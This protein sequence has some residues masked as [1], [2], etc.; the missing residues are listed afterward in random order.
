MSPFYFGS[1]IFYL[2]WFQCGVFSPSAK[3]HYLNI[4][5]N[6]LVRIYPKGSDSTSP[7]KINEFISDDFVIHEIS[8][9]KPVMQSP[10]PAQSL[11]AS[12]GGDTPLS[13]RSPSPFTVVGRP[14]HQTPR[15]PSPRFMQSPTMNSVSSQR[16]SVSNPGYRAQTPRI[17]KPPPRVMNT[18][19]NSPTPMSCKARTFT[20]KVSVPASQKG[21]S[22][23]QSY[24]NSFKS[25]FTPKA[26]NN[27]TAKE[28]NRDNIVAT[29]SVS[30]ASV[31]NSDIS[32]SGNA[33]GTSKFTSRN[34][35]GPKNQEIVTSSKNTLKCD[36]PCDK[37]DVQS[38][39]KGGINFSIHEGGFYL[40]SQYID[41]LKNIKK[42]SD[43]PSVHPSVSC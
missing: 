26:A 4:T 13:H 40:V 32:N 20:P 33:L 16:P 9:P 39:T 12:R 42:V 18:T 37:Q 17:Y 24:S 3:S 29:A 15:Q 7:I 5:P 22:V 31:S 6:N 25:T 8:P 35:L 11:F 19:I 34:P 43:C 1:S 36:R 28:N 14:M 30:N 21:L 41:C 27:S 38:T 10:Q 2:M 23:S